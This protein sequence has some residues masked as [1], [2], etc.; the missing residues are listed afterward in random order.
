MTLSVGHRLG[1]YEI[2]APIG[3]GCLSDVYRISTRC[4]LRASARACGSRFGENPSYPQ[5]HR[6][7]YQYVSVKTVSAIS[8]AAILKAFDLVR[9][10]SITLPVGKYH[11]R[12]SERPVG[13]YHTEIFAKRASSTK[14]RRFPPWRI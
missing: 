6:D 11:T 10:E 13:K 1:C 4:P 8:K 2:L 5:V 3:A 14:S 7:H 12:S 9:S